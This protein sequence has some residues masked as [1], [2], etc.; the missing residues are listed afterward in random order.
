MAA[1][2]V[3]AVFHNRATRTNVAGKLLLPA[4]SGGSANAAKI[5]CNDY[6][7]D[8]HYSHWAHYDPV[9]ERWLIFECAGRSNRVYLK[10]MPNEGAAE[11]WLVHLG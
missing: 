3:E 6:A 8:N 5:V 9:T 10:D 11:M 7:W 4:S 1:R 2:Y